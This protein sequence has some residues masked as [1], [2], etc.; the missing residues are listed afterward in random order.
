MGREKAPRSKC[1]LATSIRSLAAVL[2]PT[3]DKVGQDRMKRLS[4]HLA[5]NV[6]RQVHAV[7]AQWLPRKSLKSCGK[8]IGRSFL[9]ISQIF[10]PVG[11]PK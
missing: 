2:T 9:A 4:K 7:P 10:H 1:G 6:C 11:I 8:P 5:F 3:P